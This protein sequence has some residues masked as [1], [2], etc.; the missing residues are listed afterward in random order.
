MTRGGN[1][2]SYP[3]GAATDHVVGDRDVP[4]RAEFERWNRNGVFA[5]FAKSN[6]DKI[7]AKVQRALTA[8]DLMDVRYE[9]EVAYLLCA[10]ANVIPD[11]ERFGSGTSRSP[12]FSVD[13][14][15]RELVNIEVKRIRETAAEREIDRFSERMRTAV[16]NTRSSLCVGIQQCDCEVSQASMLA[17][18][19][20]ML[21][22]IETLIST[23]EHEV[24][25]DGIKTY[26][27]P[28]VAGV[29]IVLTRPSG[30]S[31]PHTGYAGDMFSIPY[32]Q[33]EHHKFG[34]AVLDKLG[35]V[36]EGDQNLIVI[37]SGSVTHDDGDLKEAMASL[38]RLEKDGEELFF[39]KHGFSTVAEFRRRLDCLTAVVFRS[40]YIGQDGRQ[41]HV[42]HNPRRE[43][44][45]EVESIV[46]VLRS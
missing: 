9:L 2:A 29:E 17:C 21:C 31:S 36:V 30:K 1:G 14:Q 7:R 32:T 12:D 11:Y 22:F 8:E 16:R 40:Q 10:K 42:W 13:V 6:L 5:S 15:A 37:S 19:G 44:S 24:P 23:R 27:V 35:Q 3:N 4:F 39:Q 38:H 41:S 28:A 18:E 43:P 45:K 20:A 26:P 25:T 34:D 46:E 33:K